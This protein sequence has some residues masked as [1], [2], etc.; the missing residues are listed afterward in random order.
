MFHATG[1]VKHGLEALRTEEKPLLPDSSL[2][3]ALQQGQEMLRHRS[4]ASAG[5]RMRRLDAGLGH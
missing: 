5:L 1:G 3:A 4:L 2:G